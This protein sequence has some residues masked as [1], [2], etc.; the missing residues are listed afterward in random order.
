MR[1]TGP[2]RRG[3]RANIVTG[4]EAVLPDRIFEIGYAFWKSKV[5]LS[6]VELRIFTALGDGPLDGGTLGARV[7][8]SQRS[9]RDFLDAL[10]ALDLLN[11]DAQG[12][13]ANRPD[14]ARYL[15][16]RKST[17]V[18]GPLEQLNAR[19]Y[20]SW[21]ELTQA[22]RSGLSPTGPLAEGG[23]AALYADKTAFQ[24]FLRAMTG[25][26]LMPAKKLAVSFPWHNYRTVIDVGTAQ[27]CVPVQIART[28]CHLSGGGFDLADV[29]PAFASYV[30]EHG[31]SDRLQFYPGDFLSDDLPTADVL[32]MGRILHNWE[33]PTKK[34]L[35]NKAYRAL[36]S[37]GA[38]IVYDA[39]IDDARRVRAHSLLA[40]LNMLIET[41]GGFE[42]SD[43]ECTS[44]M[45]E[46]GFHEI[47]I[48]P[49]N[50]IHTAV[51]G[52]K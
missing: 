15:D 38:L 17:Y 14:C 41:A 30:R 27:G 20:Q 10:V 25:G 51:I 43:A 5:L 42:Y 35:L 24:T 7:G 19:L 44:W 16:A 9:A 22:L 32:I 50:S 11:R 13:H 40:S 46:A 48:E 33:L 31:L 47:R 49:L 39:L 52:S 23:Y 12:R 36:P 1:R 21:G 34:R 45:Q 37:G 18:G 28:H 4:S 29:E 2:G 8:L 26:S 6:A 3:T